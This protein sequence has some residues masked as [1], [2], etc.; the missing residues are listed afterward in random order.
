MG[1]G[2]KSL[3]QVRHDVVVI[4]TE[5]IACTQTG[6]LKRRRLRNRPACPQLLLM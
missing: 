1:P 6:G 3:V 5:M 2:L 4:D